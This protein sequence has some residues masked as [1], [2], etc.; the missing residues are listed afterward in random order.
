MPRI[1]D[2]TWFQTTG[3]SA[4]DF[5]APSPA[6]PLPRRYVHVCHPYDVERRRNLQ[7]AS[8][9]ALDGAP[10]SQEVTYAA[11][12]RA[13][14]Q[15]R[16]SGSEVEF[17]G[18][19]FPGDEAYA[20][21]FFDRI[22]LLERS[23]ADVKSFGTA[24]PLPLLFDVLDGAADTDA[25]YVVF[26]NV[27]ICPTPQFYQAVTALLARGHDALVINRRTIM[28]WPVDPGLVELMAM[29]PG[30]PHEGYDCFVFPRRFLREFV[31]N[32]AVVGCGGVM[33]S[34]IFNLAACSQ[35]LLFL[36]DVHLTWHLG[37]DKV[38][39]APHL[40]DYVA[41]NHTEAL[42]TLRVLAAAN[43]TRFKEFCQ[44]FPDSRV[45]LCVEGDGSIRLQRREDSGAYLPDLEEINRRGGSAAEPGKTGGPWSRE[46]HLTVTKNIVNSGLGD[47]IVTRLKPTTFL[48]FGA[49][50]GLLAHYIAER[51]PLAP[52]YCIEPL[53]S[54]PAQLPAPLGWL[55]VDIFA[56]VQPPVPAGPFDLVLSIEVAEHIDRSKHSFLFDFLAA[57]AGH[58]VVF[59][60]ARPGQGGHGHI[61]ERP[62]EEWREEWVSRGFVFC[63]ELT[64]EGRRMCN[65]RN[66][67]HRRNLQVF[68]RA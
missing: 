62:E 47:F 55:N 31:R 21:R 15:Y 68:R 14:E 41:H 24:R 49:G 46:T 34:L 36:G 57:R 48:E 59:S 29:D 33:R 52:S 35:R 39:A 22:F 51:I 54:P 45:E 63:A 18:A 58:W 8:S 19:V 7:G 10:D 44:N 6:A 43:P 60:A 26:T 40:K 61:A 1:C 11:M 50:T 37:D 9:P 2:N 42:G 4:A 3:E 65:P 13:R 30:R 20:S 32:D 56:D 38:W 17:L 27:D 12:Q 5:L 16:A 23:A 67:N 64:D 66:I 53:V 25:E 28:G